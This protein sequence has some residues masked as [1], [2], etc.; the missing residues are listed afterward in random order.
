MYGDVLQAPPSEDWELQRIGVWKLK[1]CWFPKKCYLSGKKIWGKY[2]YHGERWITGPGEPI[3]VNYWIDRN[4]FLI[5][6]IKKGY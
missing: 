5:W 1:L 4:E 3:V 6:K 2:A